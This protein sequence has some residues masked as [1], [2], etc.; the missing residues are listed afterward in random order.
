M[1]TWMLLVLL[2]VLSACGTMPARPPECEGEY[3]PINTSVGLHPA[4]G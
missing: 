2:S 4:H 1:K 3:V